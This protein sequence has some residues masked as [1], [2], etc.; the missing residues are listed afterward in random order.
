MHGKQERVNRYIYI[1]GSDWSLTVQHT[2]Y[3]MA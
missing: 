3:L 1:E 2:V